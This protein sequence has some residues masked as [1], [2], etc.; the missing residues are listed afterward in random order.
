MR[1]GLA[2]IR[3]KLAEVRSIGWEARRGV[4]GVEKHRF[5][6]QPPASAAEVA[7]FEERWEVRLPDG[8]RDFILGIGNGGAGPYYGLLPLAEWFAAHGD[9]P[10][11]DALTL[12]FR[13]ELRRDY[14]GTVTLCDQGCTFYALLVV[15]GPTRGRI[16]NVNLDDPG[17]R[18]SPHPSFLAWYER[19]LD[20][21]IEDLEIDWFGFGAGGTVAE[22]L[23]ALEWGEP[24]ARAAAI[25]ELGRRKQPSPDVLGAVASATSDADPLVRKAA[26]RVQRER[27]PFRR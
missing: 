16:A 3:E 17:A 14:S 22:H 25:H 21:L 20:E 26:E 6:L 8:Y 18:L 11:F 2:R 9:E 10:S 4:L 27:S 19:W 7:A 12:P 1:D 24:Q 5:D 23:G 13:P 15:T